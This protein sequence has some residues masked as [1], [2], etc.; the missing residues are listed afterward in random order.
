MYKLMPNYKD[1]CIALL[2]TQVPNKYPFVLM[3]PLFRNMVFSILFINR[4]YFEINPIALNRKYT[5]LFHIW[6]IK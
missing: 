5:R 4:N 2:I 6:Y 1:S 3:Q